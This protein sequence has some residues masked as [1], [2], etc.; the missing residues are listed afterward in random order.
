MPTM[1][2]GNSARE[3]LLETNYGENNAYLFEDNLLLVY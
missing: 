1:L 3:I 2:E